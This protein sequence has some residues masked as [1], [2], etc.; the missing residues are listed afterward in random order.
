MPYK[1]ASPRASMQNEAS[2]LDGEAILEQLFFKERMKLE[3]LPVPLTEPFDNLL[4]HTSI[5]NL[6][7]DRSR[8]ILKA[9]FYRV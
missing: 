4:T 2:M 7:T 6:G 1:R 9:L 8:V 3:R 5:S